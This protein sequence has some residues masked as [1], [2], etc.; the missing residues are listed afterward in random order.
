VILV[1]SGFFSRSL[2]A[3]EPYP[4]SACEFMNQRHLRGNILSTFEWG[5][6][7]I[8]NMA[9][10]SRV[11]IDGRYDTV[12]PLE[13]I[14]KFALF[15]FNQPGGD[16]LLSEFPT[17]FVLIKPSSRSR[18]LMDARADWKLIYEDAS[19]RLYAR[20]SSV[21]ANLQGVPVIGIAQ[22]G[23]FP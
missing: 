21:A 14:Y 16:A 7:L 10:E 18:Q 13:I 17:D 15:N 20:R 3:L 8:W 23:R 19:S 1:Q 22:P 11:F 4:A 6:Y 12:F 5:E 9:P 2:T